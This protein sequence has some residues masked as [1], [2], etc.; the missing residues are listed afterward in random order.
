MTCKEALQR[1]GTAPL[2]P[3]AVTFSFSPDPKEPFTV[4]WDVTAVTYHLTASRAPVQYLALEGLRGWFDEDRIEIDRE[5]AMSRQVNPSIPILVLEFTD[6]GLPID[7]NHRL[8]KAIQLGWRQIP[9]LILLAE[10]EY[11]FR[12]PQALCDRLRD[13][14]QDPGYQML[15]S[16]V[17]KA[18]RRRRSVYVLGM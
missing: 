11:R 16:L 3:T 15:E 1:E 14:A 8:Y 18:V 4:F 2:N 10:E 9:A 13:I 12:Y 7:G 6:G 17:E 5:H